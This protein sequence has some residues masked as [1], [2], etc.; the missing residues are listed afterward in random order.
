MIEQFIRI[1]KKDVSYNGTLKAKFH[2]EGKKVL[3][4][5]AKKLGL[6]PGTFD[7]RSNMGGIAV[8]GEVTLH[9]ENIYIQF[10]QGFSN[11]FMFRSCKGR[12]DYCGGPNNFVEYE[13]LSNLDA[14]C[15]RFRRVMQPMFQVI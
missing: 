5:I 12:K 13:S 4:E 15:E 10:I 8:S 11:R 14:V 9:G 1:A 2:R 3:G 6:A 7:I